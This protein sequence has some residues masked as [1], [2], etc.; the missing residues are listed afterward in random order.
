[1]ILFLRHT[2]GSTGI[3]RNTF[4]GMLLSIM[5]SQWYCIFFLTMSVHTL[6]STSFS[7]SGI[8]VH[9][10]FL[11]QSWKDTTSGTSSI[12][13]PYCYV[14]TSPMDLFQRPTINFLAT[15]V[16]PS[17]RYAA[18]Y[19]EHFLQKKLAQS[20]TSVNSTDPPLPWI[21]CEL[22]CG[23]GLP[24]L[25]AASLPTQAIRQ[26][27]ATDLDPFCLQLV[28]AAAH[29][30]GWQDRLQTRVFDLTNSHL[31]DNVENASKSPV[32]DNNNGTPTPSA[33]LPPAD[34]YI[35]SDVF[36]SRHVALG[37]AH[38][39]LQALQQGSRVW[40]FAQS[41]RA[42]REVYLDRMKELLSDGTLSWRKAMTTNEMESLDT[43]HTPA[44]CL[45]DVDET[46]VNYG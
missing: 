25:T 34:L 45:F 32:I 3:T 2:H 16:W 9:K 28:Q 36:E 29:E 46:K 27:I 7:L 31:N 20:H 43:T 39:N 42:Q 19:V 22:G 30:Q 40:V 23:P 15:Q 35:L 8:S 14:V 13:S 10:A 18:V 38:V 21:V 11:R 4:S 44:L 5:Q 17:A 26:V 41:D 37:A 24:S 6:S 33:R 12:T 1:M